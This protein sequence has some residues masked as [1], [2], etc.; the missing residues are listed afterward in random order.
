MLTPARA[1]IVEMIRRYGVLGFDCSILEVQKLAWFLQR[2]IVGQ[3]LLNPLKL[4]FAAK[5]YGPFA[6]KLT[7]LLN[8]LDGSYL[9]CDKRLA[10]A[11]PYETIRFDDA[12]QPRLAAYLATTEGAVYADAIEH[13]DALIDGYQSPLGMEALATVDWLLTKENAVP[14]LAGIREAIDRWP[15]GPTSASRKQRLFSDK[16]ISASLETLKRI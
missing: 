14:T 16:L 9:H 5:R 13:T 4:D 12:K 6:E 10:D 2:V 3:R 7:H 1:L 15:D 8:A 11:S